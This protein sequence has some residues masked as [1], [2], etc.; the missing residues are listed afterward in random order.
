MTIPIETIFPERR[1]LWVKALR[2]GEFKQARNQFIE[3]THFHGKKHCCLAVATEVA[4]RNGCIDVELHESL[5]Q[6]PDGATLGGVDVHVRVGEDSDEVLD[7]HA[8]QRPDGT[9]WSEYNDGDL[10]PQVAEW[11]GITHDKQ[12]PVLDGTHA[13]AR[14]DDFNDSFFQIAEAIEMTE[15]W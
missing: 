14:N 10:P 8:H 6:R 12:N 2:S 1:A 4:I 15:E 13:I 3:V 9:W 5:S 7:G 11:Y